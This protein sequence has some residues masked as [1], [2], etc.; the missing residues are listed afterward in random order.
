MAARMFLRIRKR[1]MPTS[2]SEEELFRRAKARSVWPPCPI[3]F[4]CGG[5]TVEVRDDAELW[6]ACRLISEPVLDEWTADFRRREKRVEA[7][8]LEPADPDEGVRS[9]ED[10]TADDWVA[11]GMRRE[12]Y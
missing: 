12:F 1:P 5:K 10:M 3:F 6:F 4:E 11:M 9:D 8:M 7:H 2:G